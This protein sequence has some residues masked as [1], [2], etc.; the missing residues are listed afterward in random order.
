MNLRT[1]QV[2]SLLAKGLGRAFIQDASIA[3][4]IRCVANPESSANTADA[5]VV[6]ATSLVLK[7]NGVADTSFAGG[8]GTLLFATYTTLGALVDQI[9]TSANWNAEIVGGLRADDISASQ[10]LARSTSVFRNFAEINLFWD[11][12]LH[13]GLDVLFE[14]GVAFASAPGASFIKGMNNDQ[15]Q[16]HRVAFQRVVCKNDNSGD[17]LTVT[18]YELKPGNAST[19][20]TLATFSAADATELDTGVDAPL[21]HAGFGNNLLVRFA[22]AT[23]FSDTSCYL[24]AFGQRQ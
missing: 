9:N 10:I 21:I 18:V 12:S 17:A 2:N 5:V 8:T 6:S 20:A 19:V 1:A 7:V 23:T 22:G 13:L 4:R 16:Q 24:R 15:V 14:P 11:S 3:L